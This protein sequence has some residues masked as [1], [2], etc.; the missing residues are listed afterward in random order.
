MSRDARRWAAETEE[1]LGVD[2]GSA[3]IRPIV[4]NID[5]DE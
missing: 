3:F 2:T 4:V 1:K 5:I